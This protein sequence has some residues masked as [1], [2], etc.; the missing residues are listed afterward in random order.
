[1]TPQRPRRRAVA[2]GVLGLLGAGWIEAQAPTFTTKA[3]LIVGAA[4]LIVFTCAA[5]QRQLG[6]RWFDLLLCRE[7]HQPAARQAA[8]HQPTRCSQTR[9]HDDPPTAHCPP[10]RVTRATV[11]T[12][13][14]MSALATA[15]ELV[16]L[17]QH[18]RALHPTISSLYGMAAQLPVIHAVA[19]A[20]WLGFGYWILRQ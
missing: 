6:G 3:R 2:L 14:T 11:A 15:W 5:L 10:E 1:M 16:A 8:A 20:V 9:L 12:W 17:F 13:T 19:F 18:P 4:V 7:P